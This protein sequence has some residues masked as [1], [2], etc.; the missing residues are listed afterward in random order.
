MS[1]DAAVCYAA[2]LRHDARLDGCIFAGVVTTGVYCR[3]ICRVRPPRR[4]NVRWFPSAA[5][6]EVAGFRPC[7]RC[8]PETAPPP[9]GGSPLVSRVLRV[10]GAG[11]D[12]PA[13]VGVPAAELDR[14][15]RAE[16]GASLADVAHTRRVHFAKRLVAETPLALRDVA[17][18]AGFGGVRELGR[19]V[20]RT[21][22]RSPTMLRRARRTPDGVLRLAYRP[23][24]DAGAI[25]DFLRLRAIP[26]V[27]AVD[28]TSYRRTI[29]VD[30]VAGA[31]ELR[32]APRA[33]HV[34]LVVHGLPSLAT[35]ERA[36]RIFDLDA[37]PQAIAR[38]LGRRAGRVPGAWDPFELSVRA[39]LGQ[40]VTV[41]AAT[42]LA[43]R[44][45]AAFGRPASGLGAA[46][47]HLFPR[48]A[49]LADADLGRIGLPRAR[50]ATIRALAAAVA[51]G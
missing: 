15:L 32:P 18:A 9:A 5:A 39:V 44:L 33:P 43:G 21:F 35:V 45:V 26:G 14:V 19:A 12:V 42:T 37:D 23:P 11:G 7:R 1:L 13:R 17:I 36:R 31:I 20:Q 8:R 16:V 22:G 25:L 4:E 50:A 28:A 49:D 38:I 41:R 30:G 10:L 40:Q 51:S 34:E 24:L 27:E 6:A 3:P 48:A 2:A 46:L 47:S 29:E